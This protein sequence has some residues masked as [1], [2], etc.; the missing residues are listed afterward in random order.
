ML[1]GRGGFRPQGAGQRPALRA[2]DINRYTALTCYEFCEGR[3]EKLREK[4][5]KGMMCGWS[6]GRAC[7]AG[8][9]PYRRA[10]TTRRLAEFI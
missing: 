7:A 2:G 6:A 5:K 1:G 3:G 8:H 4:K 10:L 9:Y